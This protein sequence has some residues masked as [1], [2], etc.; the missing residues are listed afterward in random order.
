VR[1]LSLEPETLY[2]PE[3]RDE[4]GNLLFTFESA[5]VVTISNGSPYLST[6]PQYLPDGFDYKDYQRRDAPLL[7]LICGDRK[8][9]VRFSGGL[10]A[11]RD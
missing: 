3:L 4:N 11:P 1:I 7:F 2:S 9:S 5:E 8:V 10:L 6:V